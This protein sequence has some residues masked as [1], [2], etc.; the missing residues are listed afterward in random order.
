MKEAR[1]TILIRHRYALPIH[2]ALFLQLEN[3]ITLELW[4][5]K[6]GK[7]L[8]TNFIKIVKFHSTRQFYLFIFKQIK[9]DTLLFGPQ[10]SQRKSLQ[11]STYEDEIKRNQFPRSNKAKAT[12]LSVETRWPSVNQRPVLATCAAGWSSP[13]R[14]LVSIDSVP[15]SRS[16]M[17]R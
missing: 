9:Y 14:N 6:K 2:G 15:S 3:I 7:R 1:K 17:Q 16:S 10:S 8:Q 5:P 13:R 4:R 12:T 11:S